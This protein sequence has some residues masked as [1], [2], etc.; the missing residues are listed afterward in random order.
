MIEQ[1]EVPE[2]FSITLDGATRDIDELRDMG[3]KRICKI[4]RKRKSNF[5]KQRSR[6]RKTLFGIFAATALT[7]GIHETARKTDKSVTLWQ[8]AEL[9]CGATAATVTFGQVYKRRKAFDRDTAQLDQAAVMVS[10]DPYISAA[11][12][13]TLQDLHEKGYVAYD[14]VA[15]DQEFHITLDEKKIRPAR[16]AAAGGKEARTEAEQAARTR[17]ATSIPEVADRNSCVL[18][19]HLPEAPLPLSGAITL[20]CNG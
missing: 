17:T 14:I 18:W 10:E 5:L 20:V 1:N 6:S 13:Q 11:P 16:I 8:L 4:Q 7:I 19:L 3:V 12:E 9:A 2:K 15:A